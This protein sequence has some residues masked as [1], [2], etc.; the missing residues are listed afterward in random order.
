MVSFQYLAAYIL[1]ASRGQEGERNKLE[2]RF[3]SFLNKGFFGGICSPLT[4]IGLI[5]IKK[6]T[7]QTTTRKAKVQ[8]DI[9]QLAKL[10]S[11]EWLSEET[12]HH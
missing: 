11:V 6:T 2:K 10:M 1:R 4:E 3:Y 12:V 9:S 5:K 7:K 8:I